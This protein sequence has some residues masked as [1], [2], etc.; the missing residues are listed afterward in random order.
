MCK[1]KKSEQGQLFCKQCVKAPFHERIKIGINH[2]LRRSRPIRKD[3]IK[4][5]PDILKK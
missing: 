4:K 3:Y 5:N 1:V 2:D